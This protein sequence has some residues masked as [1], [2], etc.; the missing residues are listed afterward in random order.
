M[1]SG[2]A[3]C[4]CTRK[5]RSA[6]NRE[7]AGRGGPVL[8]QP[9]WWEPRCRPQWRTDKPPLCQ[10]G[11]LI[12]PR[13]NLPLGP[14]YRHWRPLFADK[15]RLFRAHTRPAAL[16]GRPTKAVTSMFAARTAWARRG[17]NPPKHIPDRAGRDMFS[18]QDGHF[19]FTDGDRWTLLEAIFSCPVVSCVCPTA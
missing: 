9:A 13:A 7:G 19:Y 1:A 6:G 5:V 10:N 2:S 11:G 17:S 12:A 16:L 3:L 18:Q 4:N 15:H 8:C 14:V